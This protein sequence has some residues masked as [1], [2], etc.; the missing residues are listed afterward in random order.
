M[1]VVATDQCTL[2][3][4]VDVESVQTWYMQVAASASAPA[5]PTVADPTSLGWTTAEPGFDAANSKKLYT[6]QKTTLTDGTFMW[7]AVQLSSSYTGAS[8]ALNTANAA[9]T[10]AS[11]AE[12]VA[13]NY[14]TALSGNGI[15]VTPSDA[16]PNSSGAAVSGTTSGWHISDAIELFRKGVS[17]I[18]MWVENS[19][20]KLRL[21]AANS[22]H[23]VIDADSLDIE[24]GSSNVLAT[25]GASGAQIGLTDESHMGL[26]Y[27]SMQ[28]VDSDDV[29]YMHVSDLRDR[30]GYA[31]ITEVLPFNDP[32]IELSFTTEHSLVE[33]IT[34]D[35]GTYV[36]TSF[37]TTTMEYD[38]E[39]GSMLPWDI[40]RITVVSYEYAIDPGDD[41]TPAVDPSTATVT[42]KTNNT[43]TKTFTLGTRKSGTVTGPYSYALGSEV[44]A[45]GTASHAEGVNTRATGV[46]SH[47]EG[48]D[49]LASEYLSHAEG[50]SCQA[51]GPYSHAEGAGTVAVEAYSHA[52]G[53]GTIAN[54][55]AQT[56][57]G[58]YNVRTSSRAFIIG[59]G[60]SDGNRS[61]ALTVDWSG[62]V[63]AAGSITF[64]GGMLGSAATHAHGDYALA[65]HTHSYLPLSGG[66]LTGN[67]RV[68]NTVTL[69]T[70]TTAEE[71]GIRLLGGGTRSAWVLRTISAAN[72]DGDAVLLGDGGMTIIGAGEA[73][74]NLWTALG[75]T[76]G[77]ERLYLAADS[78][79]YVTPNCGTVAN[80]HTWEF[81]TSGNLSGPS[82]GA[83]VAN[84]GQFYADSDDLTSGTHPSSETAGK[85]VI[86]RDSSNAII[87][88]IQPRFGT[89]SQ[90]WQALRFCAQRSISGTAKYNILDLR[91]DD[92]GNQTVYTNNAAAWRTALGLGTAATHADT[93]YADASHSHSE[94]FSDQVNRTANTV[95]AAP[96]GS[97]GH[98]SFRRLAMADLVSS[99]HHNTSHANI[100]VVTTAPTAVN[101]QNWNYEVYSDGEVH[102]WGTFMRTV[103]LTTKLGDGFYWNSTLLYLALPV[104]AKFIQSV[105]YSMSLGGSGGAGAY[106]MPGGSA[107]SVWSGATFY[108]PFYIARP[109]STASQSYWFSVDVW[110]MKA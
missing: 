103:A 25:F 54:D 31:T 65:G 95:L 34:L 58:R 89:A 105:N 29:T 69:G 23:V 26:D 1:A 74:P 106:C 90:E 14:I 84:N 22:T 3:V 96:N 53:S 15:W 27:H 81:N 36:V 63:V 72:G 97:A 88:V 110:Y 18:K 8:T 70:N 45:S 28:M 12:K 20:A 78:S 41:M 83:Y 40:T 39:Y 47:A 52:E 93:D 42:Y 79:V 35:D 7:G 32:Y 68:K 86:F 76:A 60:T 48:F 87:G 38:P 44:E 17:H 30:M 43:R 24:D 2:A 64:S 56:A 51:I 104:K 92:S 55:F 98:A 33:S 101:T 102:A 13:T 4:S 91:V 107:H 62:N 19:V 11:N 16:K 9:A 46:A 100:P 73:A 71:N 82:G 10:A 109:V 66:T 99:F 59:N 77:T 5:K 108:L 85:G 21:G 94:Y 67:L 37:S 75:V 50:G 49:T 80:R 61:N 57:I 6:C